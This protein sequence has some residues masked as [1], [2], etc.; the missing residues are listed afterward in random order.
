M[1]SVVKPNKFDVISADYHIHATPG[2]G[3][4]TEGAL[5][6]VRLPV[7]YSGSGKSTVSHDDN[8]TLT[9]GLIDTVPIED[10]LKW[11]E[12]HGRYA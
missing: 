7:G 11:P 9:D 12:V 1:Y 6:E 4:N 10:A 8:Y 3:R 2:D 5:G